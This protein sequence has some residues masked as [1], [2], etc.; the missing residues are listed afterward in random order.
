MFVQKLLNFCVSQIKVGNPVHEE[1]ACVKTFNRSRPSLLYENVKI[2]A[3][4]ELE[5]LFCTVST[6]KQ[7]VELKK[8]IEGNLLG[9]MSLTE[10][11]K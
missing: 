11:A 6:R 5:T 9:G 7:V 3:G 1:L 4:S 8:V 10:D 2:Q